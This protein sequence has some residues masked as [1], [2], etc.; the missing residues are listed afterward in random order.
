MSEKR[1]DGIVTRRSFLAGG[2]AAA[3][4]L[5]TEALAQAKAAPK[6]PAKPAPKPAAKPETKPEVKAEPAKP[7]V[8]VNV[9]VIGLGPQGRD[10]L[11]SLGKAPGANIVAICDT[12]QAFLNRSKAAAPNAAAVADYRQVLDNKSVQAVIIATPTH[13]HKEIALA[14]IQAGKAVYLESPMAHTIEDAR[15]IALAGKDSKAVF[16]VGNQFRGN[17]QH[18]H[19]KKFIHSG[20]LGNITLGRAQWHKK[21][22]WRRAAPT[23]ERERETNWRLDSNLSTGLVGEVG[24]HSID[25]ANWYIRELPVSVVGFGSVL[26]WNEDGRKVAD[27][28]NVILEYPGGVRFHYD[29]TLTNSYDGQHEQF[30]GTNAAVL[31]RGQ[32]AWMF[33]EADAPLYGWEVYAR[34]EEYGAETGIC[35]VADASKQLKEGKLPGKSKQDDDPGK[36]PLYFALESFLNSIRDPKEYKVECGAVEG[37]QSLV[38]ALKANE[39]VKTGNKIT[40]QKEWFAL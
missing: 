34:K 11:A 22:S 21:N 26:K 40:Y 36:T 29:A 39:A 13:Q 9:A 3:S 15:A 16:Q 31:L 5:A 20:D 37:Y 24:I 7:V 8:P 27:T 10:I 18:N 33:K 2:A 14:A 4:L 17:P 6:A 1:D 32:L 38:T 30:M 12:Y 23:P 35:L 25:I 19:V 28:V